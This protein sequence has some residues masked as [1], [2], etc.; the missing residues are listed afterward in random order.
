MS[1]CSCKKQDGFANC[2][3]VKEL[4]AELINWK[5]LF[6]RA[7]AK[8]E[9]LEQAV[10]VLQEGLE[11]YD[12]HRWEWTTNESTFDGIGCSDFLCLKDPT[13]GPIQRGGKHARESLARAKAILEGEK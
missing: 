7:F 11:F 5:T 10:A 13:H 9:K 8:S 3:K 1:T 12:S 2:C 6:D 4:Q